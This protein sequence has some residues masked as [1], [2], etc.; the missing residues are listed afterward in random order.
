MMMRRE[1]FEKLD[2]YDE[3]L[4]YE[5][6]D[7]W[8]RSARYFKYFY[9]D[10]VLTKR[11][12]HPKSLSKSFYRPGSKQVASSV[13]VFEKAKALNRTQSEN[14]AL[15]ERLRMELRQAFFA[16]FFPETLQLLTLLKSIENPGIF[17]QLIGQMA[18][19]K[20]RLSF[21]RQTYHKLRYRRGFFR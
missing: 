14:K 9:V 6:L 2:G 17:Y 16:E 4:A 8:I 20:I 10:K 5:D 21:I 3:S 12:L 7:F 15:A 13:I 19:A 18:K 1:V 11:R